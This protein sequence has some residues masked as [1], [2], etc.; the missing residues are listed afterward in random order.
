[1]QEEQG[2]QE[3]GMLGTWHEVLEGVTKEAGQRA[4][5]QVCPC[6]SSGAAA[7]SSNSIIRAT[8][9][10]SYELQG[11]AQLLR[12]SLVIIQDRGWGGMQ[13]IGTEKFQ[14]R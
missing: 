7:Q 2:S 11:E 8:S 6:V 12:K 1:M 13:W 14:S 5:F 3:R 4:G 10:G 9:Q